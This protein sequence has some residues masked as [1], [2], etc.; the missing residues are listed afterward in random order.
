M[1]LT[2]IKTVGLMFQQKVWYNTG[3]YNIEII[4]W[5]GAIPWDLGALPRIFLN[6]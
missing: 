3:T 1:F 2:E 6:I 5:E 4:C